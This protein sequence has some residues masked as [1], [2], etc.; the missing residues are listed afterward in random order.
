MRYGIPLFSN[1]TYT[2]VQTDEHVFLSGKYLERG[3]VCHIMNL[4]II[5]T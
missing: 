1:S 2:L 4:Y 3:N 5:H